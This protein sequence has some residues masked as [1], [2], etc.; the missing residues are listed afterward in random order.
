VHRLDLG[1]GLNLLAIGAHPD[2]IEI[3]CGGTLLRLLGEGRV[4]HVDWVVLTGSPERASEAKASAAAYAAAAPATPIQVLLA[5]ESVF[6]ELRDGFLPY[7][8]YQVKEVFEHL[9]A[10]VRGPD[11]VLVPRHDDAHQDHRL[12]ADLALNTWR[13]HAIWQYEIP[14]YDGD[15]RTPNLYVPLDRAACER[16]AEL[17]A[18]HFRS[19]AGRAWFTPD[20]FM[21]LA[22]LRG[23][24]CNAPS[25]FAEGFHVRKV[26]V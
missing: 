3:G 1:R 12:I 24:E 20:T 21:A 9:K 19:Q 17:L 7:L 18:E 11:L 16:K 26:V 15:L 25:G 23:V 8:G 14:K 6:G 13:D 5:D 2:D 4:G 10:A 22:R